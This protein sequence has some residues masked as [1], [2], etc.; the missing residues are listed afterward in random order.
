[1]GSVK[2]IAILIL[3][4]G[5]AEAAT[6]TPGSQEPRL[7]AKALPGT[8]SPKDIKAFNYSKYQA[9]RNSKRKFM[10]KRSA[11]DLCPVEVVPGRSFGPL[12]LGMNREE[13]EN[14]K[15]PARLSNENEGYVSAGENQ[16]ERGSVGPFHVVLTNNKLTRIRA[17]L[18]ALPDCVQI[19][20]KKITAGAKGLSASKGLSIVSTRKGTAL[21][22]EEAGSN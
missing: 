21:E 10:Q 15:L 17:D 1:V 6:K 5:V 2:L 20:E 8:E 18:E 9:R 22:I 16:F 19:G 11:T 4:A 12:K 14:L 7:G 3:V 13:I